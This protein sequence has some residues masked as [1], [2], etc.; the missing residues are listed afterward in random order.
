MKKEILK[1]IVLVGLAIF[2]F[3]SV[4]ALAEEAPSASADISVLSR[5]VWRGYALSNDSLVVQPSLN[6]SYKGL[7]FNMW[8]NLDTRYY[9][10]NPATKDHSDYTE[11]DLTLSYDW[12]VNKLNLGVG[13]IYYGLEAPASDTQEIY[14]SFGYD[15]FLSPTLTI[16]RDIASVPGVY[17]NLG[18]SHS[19]PINDKLALDLSGTIGYYDSDH[20]YEYTDALVQTNK[21]YRAFHDGTIS[22]SVN[23]PV[24]KYITVKPVLTYSFPLSGKARNQ[25]K[26]SSLVP[27]SNFLYGGVTCSI[28]F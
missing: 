9:D 16:Y 11:T 24:D 6:V 2:T 14:F 12:S 8:G 1:I 3:T 15:C 4:P 13:Y 20:L 25:I 10:A 22:A 21:T 5:Y 28:A 27:R 17:L 26:G 19:I 7:S 18:I 23:F